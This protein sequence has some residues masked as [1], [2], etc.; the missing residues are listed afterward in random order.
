MPFA[1]VAGA[2]VMGVDGRSPSVSDELVCWSLGIPDV[3]ALSL[4]DCPPPSELGNIL[5]LP[6]PPA[7]LQANI[8][9]RMYPVT[10]RFT[11]SL[12]SSRSTV[13]IFDPDE[14]AKGI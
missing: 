14:R 4:A 8:M 12:P 5:E 13:T 9:L 6:P 1:P 7:G 11:A 3:S 2:P 10:I